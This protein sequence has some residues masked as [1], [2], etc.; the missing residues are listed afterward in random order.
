MRKKNK[1]FQGLRGYAIILIFLS[2]F[3][4][5]N[6]AKGVNITTWLGGLGVELFIL[7]SGFLLIENHGNGNIEIKKYFVHKIK[8]FYPLHIV[9]LAIAIPFS[10]KALLSLDIK[11]IASL[12]SNALLVQT[13]VPASN[14]YF[15]FNAVSWYLSITVFFIVVSRLVVKFWNKISLKMTIVVIGCIFIIQ[16]LVC[17][18]TKSLII[19]HWIIYVAP[20][21]RLLDF[22]IGGELKSWKNPAL[23]SVT[24]SE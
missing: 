17:G 3:N 15:G 1:A 14:F 5:M 23:Y 2:H 13:W 11:T 12:I 19:S 20:F 16:L 9:T 24:L 18:L 7:L 10:I 6:N 21:V 8:K 4:F 22:I